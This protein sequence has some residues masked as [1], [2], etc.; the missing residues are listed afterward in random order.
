MHLRQEQE[1]GRKTNFLI[2]YK[3]NLLLFFKE[4]LAVV[5]K[6]VHIVIH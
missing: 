4:H 3:N 1:D 5:Y 6:I 2:S